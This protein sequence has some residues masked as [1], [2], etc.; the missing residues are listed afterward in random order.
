MRSN[1]VT[2]HRLA[3]LGL[4]VALSTGACAARG[5]RAKA[6]VGA[7]AFTDLAVDISQAEQT[8]YNAQIE[9]YGKAEHDTVG[10]RI[11]Q[12][13]YTTRAYERAAA[14]WPA[15]TPAPEH[16]KQAAAAVGLALDD[17]TN[18]IPAIAGVRAAL[19]TA[20]AA[21]RAALA[22]LQVDGPRDAPILPA[23][24][25][26]GLLGLL[27]LVQVLARLVS[28]GRTSVAAFRAW[29][30]KE[31]GTPADFAAA[32]ALISSEID[33]REAEHNPPAA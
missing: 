2:A 11:L 13:L 18:V 10:R 25:P 19:N 26:G 31:G 12:L 6:Q 20:I 28:E 32:D 1:R 30:E 27:A 16:V 7:L 17:L 21:L 15:G 9:G 22:S 24:I 29:L 33:R 23:Q 8:A 14:A 5:A 3:I 4:A